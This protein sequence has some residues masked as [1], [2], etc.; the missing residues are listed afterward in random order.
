MKG[1]AKM[2]EIVHYL[3]NE[4]KKL[5]NDLKLLTACIYH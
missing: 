3:Q 5:Q 1:R 2:N 4:K